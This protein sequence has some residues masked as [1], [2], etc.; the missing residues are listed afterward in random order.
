MLAV[1]WARCDWTRRVRR[2]RELS[3]W[4]WN[5]NSALLV[6]IVASIAA[7]Q[8]ARQIMQDAQNRQKFDFAKYEG[9]LRVVDSKSKTT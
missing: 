3:G 2:A 5:M 4:H 8:D 9:T 1:A 7:A 6:C